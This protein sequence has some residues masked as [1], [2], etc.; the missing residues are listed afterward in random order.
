VGQIV[1]LVFFE[2]SE[3]NEESEWHTVYLALGEE[4]TVW[5]SAMSVILVHLD[6][7]LSRKSVFNLLSEFLG[8]DSVWNGDGRFRR[9]PHDLVLSSVQFDGEFV[10]FDVVPSLLVQWN[11]SAEP[12]IKSQEKN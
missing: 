9:L 4:H 8:G 6:G 3:H 12:A 1:N 11:V 10:Q 5:K 2:V 7:G